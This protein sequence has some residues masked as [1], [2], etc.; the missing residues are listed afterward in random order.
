MLRK[1]CE[2]CLVTSYNGQMKYFRLIAVII[3]IVAAL[4]VFPNRIPEFAG[5]WLLW[6][7]IRVVQEK[8]T[9]LELLLIPMWLLIKWPEMTWAVGVFVALLLLVNFQIKNPKR[10]KL[11]VCLLWVGW[12]IWLVHHHAGSSGTNVSSN[13]GGPVVCLGDSL[14]DYG[15]PDELKKLIQQPVADFGFNGYTTDDGLKLVAEIVD[16]KPDKV[17][18]ELGGHDYKNGESRSKTEANLRS[19]IESF[20]GAGAKI[21]LVEIP[22]GFIND[23][24]YGLDRQLAREYDLD[25][26]PDTLI[27]RLVF[28]GPLIPPGCWFP[29]TQHL[30]V[31]SLHP[32]DQGNQLMAETVAGYLQ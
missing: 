9:R 5:L 24:W 22:H 14:T 29:T 6:C 8:L 10:H 20:H 31:D 26:I 2:L 23:P 32:N 12:A 13:P 30:S 16:L 21:V 18:I 7:S 1:R 27:R 19:M 4:L 28:W 15:Y 17:V 11:L 25:L 3:F